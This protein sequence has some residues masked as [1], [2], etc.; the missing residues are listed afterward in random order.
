MAEVVATRRG[1]Q[2]VPADAPAVGLQLLQD[3]RELVAA[4]VVVD[5][6]A[7][8]RD[9]WS[10]GVVEA[11]ARADAARRDLDVPAGGRPD[12]DECALRRLVRRLVLG[13]AD[14]AVRPEHLRLA[15]LL[16]EG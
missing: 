5:R 3:L 16:G 15:E 14:V 2:H 11:G 7:D 13:E 4:D 9:A 12:L 8:R 6:G 1:L 10:G